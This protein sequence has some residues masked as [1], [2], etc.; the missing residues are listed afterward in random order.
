[1]SLACNSNASS[2]GRILCVHDRPKR[3]ELVATALEEKALSTLKK[4]SA[5]IYSFVLWCQSNGHKAFP[6]KADTV[7]AYLTHLEQRNR[8]FSRIQGAVE[9]LNFMAHVLGVDSVDKALR[10]FTKRG[11]RLWLNWSRR[12]WRKRVFLAIT[13]CRKTGRQ[14]M[15]IKNVLPTLVEGHGTYKIR[16]LVDLPTPCPL[17]A[18]A[19][20][21]VMTAQPRIRSCL[22]LRT[23]TRS[24]IWSN[25]VEMALPNALQEGNQFFQ[26]TLWRSRL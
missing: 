15:L 20:G 6:L 2:L 25:L 17:R 16:F 21:H 22:N 12:T 1:M 14:S 7:F 24:Q 10:A 19:A 18:V 3:L 8:S 4:R 26:G 23:K 11:H 5:Q 9:C 13:H